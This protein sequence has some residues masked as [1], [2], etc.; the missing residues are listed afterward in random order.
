MND[1][2]KKNY[3]YTEESDIVKNSTKPAFP[4]FSRASFNKNWGESLRGGYSLIKKS[5]RIL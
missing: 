5:K 4:Q 2:N 1:D 3:F